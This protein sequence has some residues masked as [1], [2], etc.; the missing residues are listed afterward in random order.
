V[1]YISIKEHFP[2]DGQNRWPK[3][4]GGYAD[5]SIINLQICICNFWFHFS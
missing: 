4:V 3:Q 5:Y 1:L 2:E